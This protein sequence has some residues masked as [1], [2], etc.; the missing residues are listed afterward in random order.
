[1]EQ[2]SALQI[3]NSKNYRSSSTMVHWFSHQQETKGSIAVGLLTLDRVKSW[4]ASRFH[5]R[6]FT[7]PYLHK[8]LV[9]NIN[10]SICLFADDTSLCII[11]EN[12]IQ[13]ATLLNSDFHKYTHGHQTGLLLNPSKT[14]SL[15]FSRKL[16]KPLHPTLYMNQQDIITVESHK[17][18]GLTFTNDL[19]WH[20]RLNNIKSKAWYRLNVM[21]K[22]KFQLYRKSLQIFN[23]SFIRPLLEF[24][25]VLWDNCTQ[26][27]ANELEK[28]YN[29]KLH[30]LSVVPLS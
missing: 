19:S 23:F 14:E 3:A 10:S 4:C 5:S 26:Y 1:M 17:H 20:E 25:D 6:P 8:W 15:L 18:L 7:L 27:E 29:M 21:R 30:V 2:R 22:L 16:F 24:A 12:P 28:K 9:R 11:V 13:S